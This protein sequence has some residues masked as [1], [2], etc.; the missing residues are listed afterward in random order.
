[1]ILSEAYANFESDLRKTPEIFGQVFRDRIMMGAFL[2]ASD[3][4][5]A[6]RLRQRLIVGM[7]TAFERCDVM[8][9]AGMLTPLW[10]ADIKRHAM[11]RGRYLTAAW[12]HYR[13]SRHCGA[14]GIQQRRPPHRPADGRP[15]VRRGHFAAR[16]PSL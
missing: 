15:P 16:C 7:T 5:L 13:P 2:R 12:N 9:T 1:M 14:R 10:F 8:M 11:Y 3:Y 4:A 6:L